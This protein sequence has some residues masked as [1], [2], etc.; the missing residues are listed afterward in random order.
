MENL[1]FCAVADMDV[2]NMKFVS[3]NLLIVCT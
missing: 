3:G 1:I 2:G